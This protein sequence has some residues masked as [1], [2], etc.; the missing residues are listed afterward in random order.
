[1]LGL[2]KGMVCDGIVSPE[3][4]SAL[5]RWIAHHPDVLVGFPGK[6]IA[7]RLTR[8]FEDG[9]VASAEREELKVL[10]TD[11]VGETD[12]DQSGLDH[13]TRLPL[14]DPPPT[15]L[16][17]GWEYVFTGVFA[18]GSRKH[19]ERAVSDRGGATAER[20]TRR[21]DA[22]VIGSFSSPAWIE[23]THGRKIQR[24]MELRDGGFPIRIVGEEH[25]ANTV[26]YDAS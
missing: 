4:A 11:I 2:V 22:L 14:D 19:L 17:D 15:L 12:A 5:R 23:S 21:T 20:V 3:E 1:M 9:V 24:A 26:S 8:I 6:Q 18:C 10:L 16:F 13:S 25:W 7:D